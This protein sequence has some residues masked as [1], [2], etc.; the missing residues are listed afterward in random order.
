MLLTYFQ[1]FKNYSFPK[2]RFLVLNKIDELNAVII[3]KCT[4]L[5]VFR[6]CCSKRVFVANVWILRD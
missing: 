6:Y 5:I 2:E 1:N 3:N 4:K